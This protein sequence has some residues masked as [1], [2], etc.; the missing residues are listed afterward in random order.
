MALEDLHDL[1]AK[2]HDLLEQAKRGTVQP[3]MTLHLGE[4]ALQLVRDVSYLNERIQELEGRKD[5]N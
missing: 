3:E 2:V 5:S 1:A 4:L